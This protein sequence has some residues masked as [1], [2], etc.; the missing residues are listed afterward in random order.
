MAEHPDAVAKESGND[1][2]ED[3]V[4]QSCVE[5]LLCRCGSQDHCVLI[6]GCGFGALY[7]FAD[8]AAD[9]MPLR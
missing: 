7:L 9:K 8:V 3:F 1:V 6:A 2:Q 4:K 5:N